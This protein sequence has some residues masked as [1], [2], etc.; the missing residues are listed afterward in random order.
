[1]CVRILPP[2]LDTYDCLLPHAPTHTHSN[3]SLQNNFIHTP[4]IQ[5]YA[6]VCAFPSSCTTHIIVFYPTTHTRT[7]S[8]YNQQNIINHTPIHSTLLMRVWILRPPHSTYN[9]V[10]PHTPKHNTQHTQQHNTHN[11]QHTPTGHRTQSTEQ[12]QPHTI[13]TILCMCA[14]GFRSHTH[15]TYEYEIICGVPY[16]HHMCMVGIQDHI[17][18]YTCTRTQRTYTYTPINRTSATTHQQYNTMHGCVQIQIPYT[19]HLCI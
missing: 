12:H 10:L 11:T 4:P 19:H 13:T 16:T 7:N 14:R 15:T 6:C 2:T 8:E 3:P 1:V 5:F 18:D 17:C 9:C